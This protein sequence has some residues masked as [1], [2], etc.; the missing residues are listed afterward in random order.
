MRK[1]DLAREREGELGQRGI[2]N[3]DLAPC[4]LAQ[5][6]EDAERL[7]DR[8]RIRRVILVVNRQNPARLERSA[9]GELVQ[10]E[11]LATL[12]Q[13]VE[14]PIL[15]AG[16]HL[17]HA[18]PCPDIPNPFRRPHRRGRTPCRPRDTRRSSSL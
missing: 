16:E 3:F 4:Q 12:D 5:N 17:G 15:E 14:A 6:T 9:L 2:R 7:L 10:A 18:R 13:D 11:A 8:D 1:L